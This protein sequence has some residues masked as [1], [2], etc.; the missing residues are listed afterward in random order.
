LLPFLL[1]DLLLR[2]RC[3]VYE[4]PRRPEWSATRPDWYRD[5]PSNIRTD[6]RGT[7]IKAFAAYDT[8]Y[9]AGQTP[10]R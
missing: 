1:H 10:G 7:H 2:S 8:Y 6:K 4:A 5:A 9:E 3:Q